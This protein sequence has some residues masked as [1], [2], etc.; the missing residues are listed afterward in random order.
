[1]TYWKVKLSK[2]EEIM[3]Q[4]AF[5]KRLLQYAMILAQ[6]HCTLWNYVLQYVPA[7]LSYKIKTALSK[8]LDYLFHI[9][10]F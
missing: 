1:M 6:V 7:L 4:N 9:H 3:I 5:W 2:E 8:W 10:T